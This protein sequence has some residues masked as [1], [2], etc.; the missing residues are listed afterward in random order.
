[1]IELFILALANINIIDATTNGE[2]QVD[3]VITNDQRQTVEL[4]VTYTT[5]KLQYGLCD[6]ESSSCRPCELQQGCHYLTEVKELI[7]SNISDDDGS[8]TLSASTSQIQSIYDPIYFILVNGHKKQITET[9][10]TWISERLQRGQEIHAVPL[11]SIGLRAHAESYSNGQMDKVEFG[12]MMSHN[13]FGS[14][15]TDVIIPE[16]FRNTAGY[17]ADKDISNAEFLNAVDW[18]VEKNIIE[19]S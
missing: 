1:M 14:T 16:W 15:P 2:I 6:G 13:L 12:T 18:L 3:G 19:M 11:P 5:M 17:W 4:W 9:Y 10:E 8:F 7:S